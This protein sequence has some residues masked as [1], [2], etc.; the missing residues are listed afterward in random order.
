[1]TDP[2]RT[3][4]LKIKRRVVRAVLTGCAPG[5]LSSLTNPEV[6]ELV[7]LAA[8]DARCTIRTQAIDSF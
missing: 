3:R 5:D 2:P 7:G 8:R 6:I 1:V 4:N